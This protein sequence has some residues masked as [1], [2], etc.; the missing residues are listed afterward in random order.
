MGIPCFLIVLHPPALTE[1]SDPLTFRK[2][3]MKKYPPNKSAFQ[4]RILTDLSLMLY[5]LTITDAKQ[6]IRMI[7]LTILSEMRKTEFSHLSGYTTANT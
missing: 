6:Y 5:Y 7:I 1:R 2:D 3:I 4:V